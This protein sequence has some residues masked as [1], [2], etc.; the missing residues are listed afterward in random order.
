M[1]LPTACAAPIG[2]L[3]WVA[4][5]LALVRGELAFHIEVTRPDG[6]VRGRIAASLGGTVEGRAIELKLPITALHPQSP[7]QD[8]RG[9]LA[10]TIAEVRLDHGWPVALSGAFQITGLQPPASHLVVGDFALDFDGRNEAPG[11]LRGRIRDTASP[12]V[13]LSL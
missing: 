6:F 2:A 3:T 11:Q 7:E 13:V 4:A 10:G 9:G 1:A 12:L 5:P 8:W